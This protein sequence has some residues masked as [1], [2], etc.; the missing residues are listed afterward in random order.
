M[1]L[2]NIKRH[3]S[4]PGQGIAKLKR[5]QQDTVYSNLIMYIHVT[6]TT[7]RST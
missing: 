4:E 3:E 6:L 5:R 2:A 7:D 1:P